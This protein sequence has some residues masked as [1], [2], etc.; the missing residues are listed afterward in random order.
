M[1]LGADDRVFLEN[2]RTRMLNGT[3]IIVIILN[4]LYLGPILV[5]KQD[6]LFL[7]NLTGYVVFGLPL[8]LNW[9]KLPQIA[10]WYFCIAPSLFFSL[11]TLR[12]GVDS[13]LQY[14]LLICSV[15]PILFFIDKRILISLFLFHIGLFFSVVFY[16][17][18]HAPL[19]PWSDFYFYGGNIL[20]IFIVLFLLAYFTRNESAFLRK[21]M[22]A[23]TQMVRQQADELKQFYY[24]VSHDLKTPVRGLS[25]LLDFAHEDFGDEIPP[26]LTKHFQLMRLQITRLENLTQGILEY[27]SVTGGKNLMKWIPLR[28]PLLDLANQIAA[29]TEFELVIGSDV[30]ENVYATEL[31]KQVFFE[32]VENAMKFHHQPNGKIHIDCEEIDGQFQFTVFD[33]GPGIPAVFHDRIFELFETLEP[34]SKS[35]NAGVGLAIVK[36]ILQNTGG[37]IWLESGPGLGAAFHFTLPIHNT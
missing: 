24:A 4:I 10:R 27:S 8:L 3:S 36:K 11:H 9:L 13:G 12:L 23:K 14:A 15:I 22:E 34:K 5:F 1:D 19:A 29:A 37:T 33:N 18:D 17:K 31:F 30:P 21:K 26:H 2:Q 20:S 35:G 7:Q 6:P 25:N 32:L 16:L 28:Q